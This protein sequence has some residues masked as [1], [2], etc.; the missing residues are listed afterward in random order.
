MFRSMDDGLSLG[1]TVYQENDAG[2]GHFRNKLFSGT[3][4]S[5]HRLI[6]I[7]GPSIF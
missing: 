1:G 2:K 7:D 4:H 6:L 5:S 3:G